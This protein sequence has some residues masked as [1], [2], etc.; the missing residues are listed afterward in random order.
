MDL[1]RDVIAK[2][3]DLNEGTLTYIL[4]EWHREDRLYAI[5]VPKTPRAALRRLDKEM[6]QMRQSW[7]GVLKFRGG[8]VVQRLNALARSKP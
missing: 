5:R 6:L 8:S 2:W 7:D 3:P 1:F 4:Q